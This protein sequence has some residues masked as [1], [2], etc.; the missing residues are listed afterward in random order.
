MGRARK[1]AALFGAGVAAIA[2]GA[3]LLTDR[4]SG[5]GTATLT[6]VADTYVKS[7][8]PADRFGTR[9]DLKIDASPVYDVYLRF[10]VSV[11]AG[12]TVTRATLRMFPTSS[13]S[14][15]FTV[16][17]VADTTWGETTTSYS[18]A[19]AIGA[20]VGASGAYPGKAYV[21]VDVTSL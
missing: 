6:P 10:D 12:E 4:A 15:G 20:Q 17:G 21:S 2:A 8:H 7:D 11:P 19:P 13:S 14:V 16:H 9:S 18:N 5:A 3:L 1:L